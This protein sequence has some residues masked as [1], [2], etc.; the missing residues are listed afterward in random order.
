MA[1]FQ[2]PFSNIPQRFSI[3]LNGT[4]Y[5]LVNRWNPMNEGGWFIDV[6]DA[7]EQPLIMNLPLV[8]GADL[9]GQHEYLGMPGALIVY[10]DGEESAEPTLENLGT[11]SNVWLV[12]EE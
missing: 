9:F 10:T 4:L 2:I 12:T 5:H 6:Y 7:D 8:T 3:E 11:E 1:L